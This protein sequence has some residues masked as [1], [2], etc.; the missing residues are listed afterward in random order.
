MLNLAP[1]AEQY[2]VKEYL[3]GTESF[4]WTK[5]VVATACDCCAY[6]GILSFCGIRVTQLITSGELGV[7]VIFMYKHFFF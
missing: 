6:I 4:H 3:R 7:K 5:I 2:L 1:R